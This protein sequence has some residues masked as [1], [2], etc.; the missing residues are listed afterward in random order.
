MFQT[1]G[2]SCR[3][4][5]V[6]GIQPH[7]KDAWIM[8][9]FPP[10][11][12]KQ[13][14]CGAQDKRVK[15]VMTPMDKVYMVEASVRLNFEHMMDI[16]KS[17]YTRIPVYERDPQTIIGILYTKDLIL[18]DP[19]V[20]CRRLPTLCLT[21]DCAG[22]AVL[23]APL[24]GSRGGSSGSH[25]LLNNPLGRAMCTASTLVV[26]LRSCVGLTTL[27]FTH[28]MHAQMMSWRSARWCPSTARATCS[29][30]STTPPSTRCSQGS[31]LH[32]VPPCCLSMSSSMLASVESA[33]VCVSHVQD[34]VAGASR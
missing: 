11:L 3:P 1:R 2:V 29:T 21:P 23:P 8:V 26:R 10:M 16:Y 25:N 31:L 30:S 15:D 24:A 13:V 7:R 17:G 14:C 28:L 27:L 20:G 34:V 22:S 4:R 33:C 18:V 6:T 32:A 12:R 19:G 5:G 9:F